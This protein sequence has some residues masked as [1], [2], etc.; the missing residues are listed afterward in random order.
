MY[1]IEI[2]Y[3]NINRKIRRKENEY[4]QKEKQDI[5]PDEIKA[6]LYDETEIIID[7]PGITR[8]E[9]EKTQEKVKSILSPDYYS[10]REGEFSYDELSAYGERNYISKHL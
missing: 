6:N 10:R 2:C 7:F 8:I 1:C 3:N 9:I 4:V 5:L